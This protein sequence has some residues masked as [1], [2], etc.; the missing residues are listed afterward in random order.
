MKYN[1]A[2][3]RYFTGTPAMG[4]LEGPDVFAGLAGSTEQGAWVR[5][6]LRVRGSGVIEGRF[7][8]FG[9]PHTIASA[10]WVAEHAAQGR[11]SLGMPA[12][13]AEL[14]ERFDVP[15]EKRGRLLVVEDAWTAATT[16]SRAVR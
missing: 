5:F 12:T 16:A 4:P 9:C 11:T 2:T 3:L 10:S 15:P 13:V 14:A 7:L 1:A 6:D 8:A